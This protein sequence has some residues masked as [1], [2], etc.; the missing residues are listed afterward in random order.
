MVTTPGGVIVSTECDNSNSNVSSLKVLRYDA[1]STATSLNATAEWNLTA[2]LPSAAANSGL[3]AVSWIPDSYLTAHGFHD[4]H[5]N[6]A[7]DP[8]AYSGHGSGRAPRRSL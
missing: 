1:S 4:E 7:Y 6:T 8:A 5:T 2:D 3:E